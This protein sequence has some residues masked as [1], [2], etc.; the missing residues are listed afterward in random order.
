VDAPLVHLHKG[1]AM[2]DIS[3]D[4]R[5]TSISLRRD[6]KATLDALALAGRRSRTATVEL[7]IDAYL[8][9]NPTIAGVVESALK[10]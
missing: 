1:T 2:P 9:D 8:R 4:S 3:P 10:H 7:L 5:C 6:T